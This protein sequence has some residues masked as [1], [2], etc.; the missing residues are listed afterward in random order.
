[1]ERGIPICGGSADDT[2]PSES[3]IYSIL[4]DQEIGAVVAGFDIHM[5][6]RKIAKAFTYLQNPHCLFLA[7]NDD[8][9]YPF[10]HGPM[11]GK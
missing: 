5:N 10:P 4:P 3:D 8:A 11:P 1:M 2:L 6:F 9:T 7:T